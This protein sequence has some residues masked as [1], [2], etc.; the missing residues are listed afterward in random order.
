ME[1]GTATGEGNDGD[2]IGRGAQIMLKMDAGVV[3]GYVTVDSVD[4]EYFRISTD[5]SGVVTFKQSS[6]VNIWSPTPGDSS[7]NEGA[8]LNLNAVGG[9]TVADVMQSPLVNAL[10]ADLARAVRKG[11]ASVMQGFALAEPLDAEQQ[12]TRIG[13]G[14]I[15]L[16]GRRVGRNDLQRLPC[17][18][19]GIHFVEPGLGQDTGDGFP[20][21]VDANQQWDR[22]KA[23][24]ACRALEPFDLTW[25]E[26]PVLADDLE[27]CARIAETITTPLQIGEN[28]HGP[29]EMRTAL[30]ASASDLVMP[31]AQ[32]IH[33]VTGWLEAAALARSAGLP[34]SSHTF[35]EASAQLLCATPTVHWIEVLDA[36]GGLRQAPLH[37]QNG[38]L[39]P[40]DT[41]GIG[42]EWREDQVALHRL[43]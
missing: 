22:Q 8:S 43:R 28:F 35:V 31:D 1:A 4:V 7:Y 6:S 16:G 11:A 24:R 17:G 32:F 33:G 12:L 25:I 40:W 15:R 26:E 3:I 27:G 38:H 37:I 42:L 14:E 19:P 18:A 30:A 29:S 5:N 34:M 20:L 21:M 10:K 41:P 23:T 13:R 39:M 2:G 36:A 9:D